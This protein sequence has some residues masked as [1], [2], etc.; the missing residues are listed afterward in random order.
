LFGGKG[1]RNHMD[2]TLVGR[3]KELEIA[4]L[5]IRNGI[6]VFLPLVDSGADL[7]AANREASIVVPVQVK[8]RADALNLD[9]NKKRDF[10]RFEKANTVVAFVIGVTE[11]RSWFIPFRDWITKAVDNNRQDDLVFVRI[12]EN[13]EWLSKYE[14][15]AGVLFAFRQLLT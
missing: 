10:A 14:G 1:D 8:Y 2:T 15:D 5:L 11:Q 13:E 9:L 12:G 6:Y 7:L 4:G 3:A